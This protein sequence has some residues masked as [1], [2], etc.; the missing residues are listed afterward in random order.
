MFKKSFKTLAANINQSK[1]VLLLSIVYLSFTRGSQ[2]HHDC[3]L[4][5]IPLDGLQF[6]IHFNRTKICAEIS[7]IKS[8]KGYNHQKSQN[9]ICDQARRNYITYFNIPPTEDRDDMLSGYLVF[10]LFFFIYKNSNTGY[11][12]PQPMPKLQG[13]KCAPLNQNKSFYRTPDRTMPRKRRNVCRVCDTGKS[14][15]A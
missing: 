8:I 7:Y 14:T 12:E 15:T 4:P 13:K 6:H 11:R 10:F 2:T 1:T 9:T 5:F 3:S